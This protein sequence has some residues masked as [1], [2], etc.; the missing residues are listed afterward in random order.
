MSLNGHGTKVDHRTAAFLYKLTQLQDV[1][2]LW[3]PN[4]EMFSEKKL[5]QCPLALILEIVTNV[6]R[7]PEEEPGTMQ[8]FRIEH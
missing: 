1:F 7:E 4:W 2:G 6:T 3:F 8:L 5:P